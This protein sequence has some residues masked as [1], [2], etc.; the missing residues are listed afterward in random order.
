MDYK[1]DSNSTAPRRL[2]TKTT[3]KETNNK[4]VHKK[5]RD[6]MK[7]N[8]A[9]FSSMTFASML[10]TTIYENT[11]LAPSSVT[12]YRL[13]LNTQED[14]KTHLSLI[15]SL[16]GD[17][18]LHTLPC[19]QHASSTTDGPQF[20]PVEALPRTWKE[21]LRPSHHQ[22]FCLTAKQTK[23]QEL[24]Y[25]IILTEQSYV[26]DLILIYKVFIIDTLSWTGLP[27]CVRH[28]FEIIFH[29]IR[30]HLQLLKDLRKRQITQYPIINSISDIFRSYASHI[31]TESM[32]N[33]DEFGYYITGSTIH[34]AEHGRKL[35]YE[36]YLDIV[37]NSKPSPVE[38]IES[39][40][41]YL[42]SSNPTPLRRRSSAFSLNL[43]RS[44][45]VYVFLFNDLIVCTRERTKRRTSPTENKVMGP[46]PKKDTYY[47]PSPDALFKVT[48]A[49]GRVT[50]IDKAITKEVPTIKSAPSRRGSA[51]FQS[52]RRQGRYA[53]NPVKK[54]ANNTLRH[55]QSFNDIQQQGI[56]TNP[57]QHQ[58]KKRDGEDHPLQFDCYIATRNVAN[59]RFEAQTPEDKIAWC[60]HL[61][62]VLGEHVQR[63]A[64]MDDALVSP[65]PSNYS[66]DSCT[67]YAESLAF[68]S[69][70]YPDTNEKME[71]DTGYYTEHQ[72]PT[73]FNVLDEF[74][75]SIWDATPSHFTQ[76]FSDV[77]KFK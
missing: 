1:F 35:I 8:V 62:T 61:E 69:T 20:P 16:K 17:F 66:F 11:E 27:S 15:E 50:M 6:V 12:N 18:G 54:I 60:T 33:Q 10:K 21:G 75:D 7:K 13:P 36:G 19:W 73:Y 48:N 39:P 22:E 4:K 51:L 47:G 9:F 76:T 63:S 42:T 45:K 52:L 64:K 14:L 31:I 59:I 28:L 72:K 2:Y 34:I 38:R 41:A 49:P 5:A 25:E 46:P 67:S 40:L 23:Y 68:S 30:V 32:R 44:D 24:V 3:Q 74:G 29:I 53:E 70:W 56:D 26:D 43:K 71:I 58:H 55:A 77:L 57:K 37:P 65:S